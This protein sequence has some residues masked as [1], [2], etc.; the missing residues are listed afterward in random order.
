MQ[1]EQ[2]SQAA[3]MLEDSRS[4][5]KGK[6]LTF[7][8][9]EQLFGIPIANVEQIVSMQPITEV[10]DYPVYVKGIISIRGGGVIPLIDLR[11]RLGKQ[12]K[13]FNDHTCIISISADNRMLGF[14][15]DAVDAVTRIPQPDIE[16]PPQIGGDTANQYLTGVARISQEDGTE[17]IVL[18]LNAAKVWRDNEADRLS[19]SDQMT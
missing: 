3:Q 14:I 18:C 9:D 15:V 10:P 4:E 13:E 7:W 2:I 12:E 19:C 6:W 11:L 8:L 5:M 17:K 16:P 1:D